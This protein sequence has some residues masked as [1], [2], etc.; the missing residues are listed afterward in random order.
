[1]LICE[2]KGDSETDSTDLIRHGLQHKSVTDKLQ[3]KHKSTGDKWLPN[4]EIFWYIQQH[5]SINTK[6]FC[7]LKRQASCQLQPFCIA[8]TQ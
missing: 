2:E 3:E 1:M 4:Q 5:L 6:L 7:S 8:G